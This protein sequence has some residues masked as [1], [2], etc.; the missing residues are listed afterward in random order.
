MVIT[1]TNAD[2]SLIK[3]IEILNEKLT[4]PYEIINNDDIPTDETL[5][6]IQEYGKG[7]SKTYKIFESYMQEVDNHA[8]IGYWNRKPQQNI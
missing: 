2:N 5:K 8:W 7:K 6:A 1:I 4:N 3:I